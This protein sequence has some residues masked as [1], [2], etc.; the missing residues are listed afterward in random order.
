MEKQV[1]KS[2]GFSIGELPEVFRSNADI[3]A[4]VSV[5]LR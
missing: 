3:S 1:P 4:A 5:V 2:E